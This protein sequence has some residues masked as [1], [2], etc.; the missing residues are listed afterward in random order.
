MRSPVRS[1]IAIR[2][3]IGKDHEAILMAI[4]NASEYGVL[5]TDLDHVAIACNSRFGEIFDVDPFSVVNSDPIEVRRMVERL[6]PDLTEWEEG[7]VAVYSDPMATQEDV[8]ELLH[9]TRM[10]IRR[11]TGP[12]LDEGGKVIGRL[13]SFLDIT[14]DRKRRELGDA[15]YRIGTFFDEVPRVVYSSIVETLA[16]YYSTNAI[17]SI[18]S[19]STMEFKH[20][21]SAIPEVRAMKSNEMQNSYCQFTLKGTK[22]LCIQN[23]LDD[24]QYCHV[25]PAQM[26]IT[27]YLGV[28]INKPNGEIIGT[29]CILDSNSEMVLTEEDIHFVSM[30]AVRVSAEIAREEY[31]AEKIA[32]KQAV[33]ESQEEDLLITRQVLSAMNAAFELLGDGN[34]LDSLISKQV[35]LMQGLLGIDFI[36]LL[37]GKDSEEGHKG[38]VIHPGVKKPSKVTTRSALEL[39]RLFQEQSSLVVPL[40]KLPGYQAYLILASSQSISRSDHE[41]AHLEAL[42]EQVSLLLS[43]H[44]LQRELRVAYEDLKQTHNQLVQSE[45]LSVVGTLAASTAHDIKNILSSITLELGLGIDNPQRALDTVKGH[46]DR[47]AVLAHRLLSYAKPKMVAMQPVNIDDIIHRVLALTAAHTRVTNVVVVYENGVNCNPILGDP[48]Q[49]EHLFINLVMNAVQ[50]MHESGGTLTIRKSISKDRL[51]ITVSDTGKGM[52]SEAQSRIFQP[53]SSTR[54]EGFGL[55]L[56]S[57]KRIADEHGGELKV[58]SKAN[59]GTHITVI[60][61]MVKEEN[62]GL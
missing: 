2:Q 32:Q 42:I 46:L 18:A 6:I 44:L 19:G 9:S 14:R 52:T 4:L 59:Q 38:Y 12:V 50:A 60:L 58:R 29:L 21:A 24:P 23:A 22:P 28:P 15:L 47:F 27:R 25:M 53:F 57:C 20:V 34:S 54:T 26:G 45:K 17:I 36:G 37:I 55:G 41:E 7:L 8:L 13:W 30:V 16:S 51:S 3:V 31:L 40:R 39:S 5:L 56:Y 49:I 1:D 11:Y 43:T 33:V 10:C 61:K 35:A 48:H 62:H